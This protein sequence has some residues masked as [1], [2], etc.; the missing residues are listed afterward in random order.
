MLAHEIYPCLQSSISVS[1]LPKGLS[2]LFLTAWQADKGAMLHFSFIWYNVL[3]PLPSH[4]TTNSN[5]DENLRPFKSLNHVLTL[6]SSRAS[7]QWFARPNKLSDWCQASLPRDLGPSEH[8]VHLNL[9][10]HDREQLT[11]LEP[12]TPTRP[13]SSRLINPGVNCVIR[14]SPR[15]RSSAQNSRPG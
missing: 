4:V 6:I 11:R 7:G 8:R 9:R 13:W 12:G 15:W 14:E 2:A 5:I 3:A 1:P 10:R